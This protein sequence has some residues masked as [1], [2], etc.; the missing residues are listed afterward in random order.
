[1]PR[2][3]PIVLCLIA[4]VAFTA[5][6]VW[7]QQREVRLSPARIGDLWRMHWPRYAVRYIAMGEHD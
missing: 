1:M 7:A 2:Q 3:Q 6:P 4:F 5:A